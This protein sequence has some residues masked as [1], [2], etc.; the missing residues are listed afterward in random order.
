MKQHN[1][2]EE[3]LCAKERGGERRKL[4]YENENSLSGSLSHDKTNELPA[5]Q[6]T[7]LKRLLL[8]DIHEHLLEY[9]SYTLSSEQ[10]RNR[11]EEL[12]NLRLSLS[13]LLVQTLSKHS[14]RD[15][16]N[17]IKSL[18]PKMVITIS[19]AKK[20]RR[21]MNIFHLLAAAEVGNVPLVHCEWDFHC[22]FSST[23]DAKALNVQE[24]P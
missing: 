17:R 19:R 23:D 13:S 8:F 18:H 21:R 5:S 1:A 22:H 12:F 9:D 2:I 16:A 14:I 6:G 10:R 15:E 3:A 24:L 7:W 11:F 4:N 20:N